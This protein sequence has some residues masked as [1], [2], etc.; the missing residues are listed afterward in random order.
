MSLHMRNSR[1]V[2]QRNVLKNLTSYRKR[3]SIHLPL[4]VQLSSVLVQTDENGD[5]P[6]LRKASSTSVAA[7]AKLKAQNPLL[8]QAETVG[9]MGGVSVFSTLIFLEKLVWMSSRE[10]ECIARELKEANL[11]PLEAG[12]NVRIG[13]L[14]SHTTLAAGFYQEK[15]QNQQGFE[16]VLPDKATMEHVVI[17]ATESLNRR[18]MEGAR[19]LLR[20][21]IQVLLV[22]AVNTVIIA[23]DEMLGLLPHDDPLLKKC[24]DPMD[25][26]ARSTVQWAK[27]VKNAPRRKNMK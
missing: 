4:A 10:G 27:S 23:Y 8:S 15:L 16:V 17:A 3:Q 24:V 14:A 25:A 20:I 1:P 21:A 13:L 11:K 2:L 22:R 12:S 7:Q 6:E 19:N 18:D 26:L 5:L 9:I